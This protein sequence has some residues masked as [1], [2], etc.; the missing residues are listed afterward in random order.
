MLAILLPTTL[1]GQI[2]P[3]TDSN[4]NG[5]I[6]ESEKYLYLIQ[7]NQFESFYITPKDNN[8]NTVNLPHAGMLWYFLQ[9]EDDNGTQYYYIVN[10][11]TGK[12]I[13]NTD[14][15]TKGRTIQLLNFDE[16][17]T[18]M[19]K[20]KLVE[21]NPTGATGYYNID[22][23]PNES[24]W[25]GLNKRGG[26]ASHQE[27]IR[28]TDSQYINQINSRWKFI[29]YNGTLAWP[30]P[31]FIVS[32][33]SEKNYYK[34]RNK[35]N[36]AYYISTTPSESKVTYSNTMSSDM[37][38]YF[39]EGPS[40]GLM[41]YYHIINPVA[42]DM[43]MY[44]DGTA[45]DGSDQSNAVS[46]K[47]INDANAVADRFLFVIVQA[48]V[49]GSNDAPIDGYYMIVPKLLIGNLWSSNSLGP[50][51][52]TNGSNMGIIAGRG[53][54]VYSHWSFETTDNPSACSK[55]TIT[56]SSETGKITITSFPD[57]AVIHYTTDGATEP[58]STEGTPYNEPFSVS[59]PVTI[60]AI[61]TKAG[62]DDSTVATES[63]DQVAAPGFELTDDGKVRL[64][65]ATDG[66]SLYYEM[67][68]NPSD[69]TTSSIHYTGSI[70]NAAG[71]YIKAIAV[72][73]DMINSTVETSELISFTCATP[74]IRK[75][76]PTTF[77]I[78]SSFPSGVNIRYTKG[79]N[80]ADPTPE[81]G[82][83]Y[84]GP[85]TFNESELPFTVKAIAYATNYSNSAVVTW[86]H[87]YSGDYLT[88]DI[89]TGGTLLWK[90]EGSDATKTIEYSI[91]NNEEWT[92][93]TST[94][95]GA[96]ITVAS[97]DV[98]RLRGTNTRYCEE[99][100]SNYSHFADGSA[101]FN[102]SGNMM[103][104]TDGDNFANA[105]SLPG[106]WT[107]CQ[108]FKQSKCIS[109]ENLILP[110]NTLTNYCYRAMF[111]YCTTLT[112]PPALPATTLAQGC[113]WYMFEKCA[114]SSAPDLN[115]TALVAE[116][117]GHMFDGCSSL[118]CIKCFATTGINT[119]QCLEKWVLNVALSGTFVKDSNQTW[120]TG[121]SGIPSGW[122]IFN[123]YLLYSP[124][125][126]CNGEHITISCATPE[127][128]IYYRLNQTGEFSSYNSPID[129]NSNTT[130]EAYSLK[131][132]NTSST[133]IITFEKYD[134]PLDESTRPI[135]SW[136][137]GGAQ[138][139]LPYSINGENGHSSSYWQGTYAFETTITLYK[140]QPTY[141]WFQHA[142][143]SADIYVDD[144]F[145]TTHWG[146]YNAF[147]VD[148]SNY[149]HAGTNRIKVILNN[150]TRNTLAPS[151]G[152][153]NFNA[154]LGKVK[155]LTSPVMPSMDYGY[156]G[157]HITATNVSN[158]SATIN[159]KTKI[160]VGASVVCT[161]SD[162][163]YYWTDTQNSTGVE[164]T[165][166]T[167]IQNP[168]L[169][170]GTIDPHLYTIKLEIY[171]DNE[172]YH[173]YER[174]YGLRYYEYAINR[175][176]ILP[177]GTYTG[178]LLNG[179]PCIL[180]GVCMHHDIEGKAN[181]L[182]DEDIAND[183]AI[184]KELGC[185]FVRLAH[186]PHPKEIYDWC[187]SLGIIVQTEVPCVN[188][189]RS[190]EDA[191]NPC[192]Q[193]YYDHLDIQYEDMV[194]Q[195][196]NH[197]CILFWGL[198]NEATTD[199]PSWAGPKLNYYRTLIK[200]IDAERWVGYVVAKN[201]S[202]PSGDFG[203]P[204]MDW[205]GC[206]IY[207]GWY[208]SPDS[209]DPSSQLNTRLNNTLT[210]RSK[211]LAFSE[212][213]CGGTQSCHSE[214]PRTTTTRGTNQ[215]RHDI[216]YQMWLHEGH[217]A[218][219]KN[220]PELLFTSQWQLFDIAVW[221]RQ[222][223]YKVCFDGGETVFENNELKFLN[224]KGLVERDHKTKKDPFYLYKA[225]WNQTD[226]FVHICGKDYK[227]L[228]DRVIKCYTNDGNSLS[229]YVNNS[230]EP[231]ETVTVTNNIATFTARTFQ[232]GD[233][234]KVEGT[235]IVNGK[236]ISDTFTFTNFSN[237]NVFTT[238]GN[239]NEADN[240][241][242]PIVPANG[243]D[244]VIM[245]KATVPSGYTANAGNI[246]LYGGTLTI[247]DGGQLYHSNEGVMATVQK[248]IAARST[249]DN[250]NKGWTFIASPVATN[251]A[252]T[253]VSNMT[254][255]AFDLY[256]FN[257]NATLEWENYLVHNTTDN[258]FL[259]E[260]GQGY[261]Y[262][263]ESPIT[264]GFTGA[265]N[266]SNT[267]V[268]VPIDSIAGNE[269]AGWNLVG[270]PF[271][272]NAVVDRPYY[273]MNEDGSAILATEQTSGTIAPCTGIMVHVGETGQSVTFSK[274][275][276]ITSPSNGNVSITVVQ[277]N[278]RGASSTTID[279]AIV[280]FSKG[281]ELP[282]FYFGNTHAQLYIPQGNKEFA[283][284][285]TE[286]QG[287]LPINFRAIENGQYTFTISTKGIDMAYLH[288]IDNM[289]GADIDLLS[290]SLRAERSNPEN[291]A[292]YTFT[293]KTTDYESRFKL[294]F[295]CGDANDDNETFAFFSNGDI[296]INGEGM[297]QVIDVMGRVIV[298][299][300]GR[301]RCIPTAGM[302]AGVYVLRLIN[303]NDVKTQ[304][305]MIK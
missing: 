2:T 255:T 285:A 193:A 289:T 224:N 305:I 277:A 236:K 154:T 239:W 72:K 101:T 194:R 13:C 42:G 15:A 7:T 14:Y 134:C 98:V 299:G 230:S 162:G 286:G 50:K 64:T 97:G 16:N 221:N 189:F 214:A 71:Q 138:I 34:I 141:L 284:V 222:E 67:G 161:I 100:K 168:H 121:E 88:L 3:T 219:I 37:V 54:D 22:I 112:T 66:A 143:Q 167:T 95:N 140:K 68:S 118:N 208:D 160:P 46:I 242:G 228:T 200:N 258:P 107:F 178:F 212:Y 238:N 292:S 176:G 81:S 207:I 105:T 164:Q 136:T 85:V 93:I 18:D 83:I 120:S 43:Y 125:I 63:F 232:A 114:I 184:I 74:I 190:P 302:T 278:E 199:N 291:P 145:V 174:P 55:P 206:N 163:T 1:Y 186:Y 220:K 44:Y 103:S 129:F 133:V 75:T 170:N 259:L 111:S 293:A 180:R 130:V 19:F 150:T 248:T 126:S 87:D 157:F 295:V 204:N 276:P 304:K 272:C 156:D 6:E 252:P 233:V 244:V 149:V 122:T 36:N 155:L 296:I 49:V 260:N 261:L 273:K 91:N 201:C 9:A 106:E 241:S 53:A 104:L 271:T 60:M 171:K 298:S 300:G 183:F 303:G 21:N 266:P 237:D 234:I 26:N 62:Y 281:S 51:T 249:V 69:P 254:G 86:P 73:D 197:P 30:D 48:A 139:T 195:H 25:L 38:W 209:N 148:I 181:A 40:D 177:E 288:L 70:N 280:S 253:S 41:K 179:Q 109:A 77:T 235:T 52:Q 39:K 102:I 32:T 58:S 169:W 267:S 251:V 12:Y 223:G 198:F 218:A 283:I 128:G 59:S 92:S 205:F 262:N 265:I 196:Y 110:A 116:C 225:W 192:P 10:N 108:F 270:N 11:S 172:L 82:T 245:A 165:F 89:I 65:C 229:L 144:V 113:Y 56:Y 90:A 20:F 27:G 135:N 256:R 202:N 147:F 247:A 264:L 96:P 240:W 57:D 146:G 213:G 166:T 188:K 274:E 99:N 215:P 24:T 203:N 23:K 282:K 294:V 152:D 246:D 257:Q 231:V 263:N 76:S 158:S 31:P 8:L 28:L 137:Y 124:D 29:P 117:Y 297:L 123:D 153:F 115:A 61:A 301:K 268:S 45:T 217:I 287:E 243:S 227:K 216:E 159:V 173:R 33:D 290:S 80:P 94:S 275:L 132:N 269:F 142:D 79:T 5:T 78:I 119:S 47:D 151:A 17:S 175:E 185:N 182:S 191:T 4:G 250:V 279:N 127:A 226:K 131:D 84:E 211:P 35:K 187:D 210:I